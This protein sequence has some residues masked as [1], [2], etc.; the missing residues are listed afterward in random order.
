MQHFI[1]NIHIKK[2]IINIKSQP[3]KHPEL[4]PI[5]RVGVVINYE[6]QLLH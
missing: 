2:Y 4:P 5:K 6:I 3:T 1:S